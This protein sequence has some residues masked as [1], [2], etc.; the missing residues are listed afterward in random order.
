MAGSQLFDVAVVPALLA[1]GAITDGGSGLKVLVA[2]VVIKC[3]LSTSSSFPSS[4]SIQDILVREV[5]QSL[6]KYMIPRKWSFIFDVQGGSKGLPLN[7]NGKVD[8]QS[9]VNAAQ[10]KFCNEG[11]VDIAVSKVDHLDSLITLVKKGV[12]IASGLES[13]D[14]SDDETID[15]AEDL[16]LES[17]GVASLGVV[18][19]CDYISSVLEG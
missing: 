6:P 14:D 18:T 10:R 8:R 11:S 2:F 3:D 12:R 4:K 19:F 15:L 5:T 13:Y 7:A 9:L 1:R 17:A 16:D